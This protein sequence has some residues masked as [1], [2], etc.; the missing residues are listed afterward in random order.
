MDTPHVTAPPATAQPVHAIA[1]PYVAVS[2]V[3]ATAGGALALTG[4][5]VP[6][7]A[8]GS[9]AALY[10]GALAFV[11]GGMVCRYGALTA[12]RRRERFRATGPGLMRLR[13][14]GRS[15][16]LPW[17]AIR[18]VKQHRLRQ[19]LSV[20]RAD[21]GVWVLEFR[22]SGFPD[23]AEAIARRGPARTGASARD[24]YRTGASEPADTAA[25]AFRASRLRPLFPLAGLAVVGSSVYLYGGILM[26]GWFLCGLAA[27]VW[28]TGWKR[29]LIE[30]EA[31]VVER[32]FR[33]RRIPLSQIMNV[34]IELRDEGHGRRRAGVALSLA[35]G[36]TLSLAGTREGDLPLYTA[37]NRAWAAEEPR[38]GR[39][40]V[41]A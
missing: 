14:D 1:R 29:I 17:Q 11:V 5:L 35:S 16:L 22:L 10:L 34:V 21:G 4:V 15:E 12:A 8:A 33:S 6:W 39:S 19:C 3:I 36:R 40:A 32:P 38:H 27:V 25:V 18:Q 24:A 7:I 20:V 30:E 37:L 23:L 13:G 26:G 9:I 41:E 28:L 31:V 2:A